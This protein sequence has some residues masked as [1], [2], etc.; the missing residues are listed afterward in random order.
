MLCS[1]H[2]H[3][4][5]EVAQSQRTPLTRLM[6]RVLFL[7]RSPPQSPISAWSLILSQTSGVIFYFFKNTW[8]LNDCTVNTKQA[9][10]ENLVL[11]VLRFFVFFSPIRTCMIHNMPGFISRLAWSTRCACAA[12]SFADLRGWSTIRAWSSI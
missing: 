1:V 8:L 7:S 12:I 11:H 9:T 3:S 4:L 2:K 5:H 6:V 10:H